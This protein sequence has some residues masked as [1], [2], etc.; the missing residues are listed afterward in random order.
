MISEDATKWLT[1]RIE[2]AN[3]LYGEFSSTHEALGVMLEEWDE[4][5]EAIRSNEFYAIRAECLDLAA[6]LIRLHD[7]LEDSARLRERSG[8]EL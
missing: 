5:R 3:R 1:Q 7:Q 8:I 2:T 4:V 6:V